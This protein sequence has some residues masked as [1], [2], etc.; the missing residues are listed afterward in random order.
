MVRGV[1]FFPAD[2]LHETSKASAKALRTVVF[3]P[4]EAF[5]YTWEVPLTPIGG[6]LGFLTPPPEAECA[7]A[8]CVICVLLRVT[9]LIGKDRKS[10]L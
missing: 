1:A 5:L 2:V 8:S 9:V 7:E 4:H 6:S 10:S 3:F